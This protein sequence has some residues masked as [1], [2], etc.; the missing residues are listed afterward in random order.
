MRRTSLLL[1]VALWAIAT[2]LYV[3]AITAEVRSRHQPSTEPFEEARLGSCTFRE[4]YTAEDGRN[5]SAFQP[6]DFDNVGSMQTF[7]GAVVTR[8]KVP[9]NFPCLDGEVVR[10][11][12]AVVAAETRAGPVCHGVINAYADIDRFNA[13]LR[14]RLHVAKRQTRHQD[15]RVDVYMS[16]TLLRKA[17]P[18]D[19]EFSTATHYAYFFY[20]NIAQSHEFRVHLKRPNEREWDESADPSDSSKRQSFHVD[21]AAVTRN[22][23]CVPKKYAISDA[24][25]LSTIPAPV[26]L[27]DPR[28]RYVCGKTFKEVVLPIENQQ[29]PCEHNG[30]IFEKSANL[31]Q[32]RVVKATDCEIPCEGGETLT[33]S[34]EMG[35]GASYE[36]YTK[37]PVDTPGAMHC[38][39]FK[40]VYTR[41]EHGVE[42]RSAPCMSRTMCSPCDPEVHY[43]NSKGARVAIRIDEVRGT[44]SERIARAM[45]KEPLVC[46]EEVDVTHR[47]YPGRCV[48]N[49]GV[50][51]VHKFHE[52]HQRYRKE[53]PNE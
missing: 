21:V 11:S 43:F 36:V 15:L 23:R 24:G 19:P 9:S 3:A 30:M 33:K 53:C 50:V 20:P 42:T 29:Y 27:G 5:M 31:E 1:M 37:I 38:L 47:I 34:C 18:Y 48:N 17:V 39:D 25:V 35:C 28:N 6:V 52:H 32:Q 45:H 10:T 14:I 8:S 16:G 46:D 4:L 40:H 7:C 2:I 22:T 12:A 51:L 26:A 49:E 44:L 13:D 41:D